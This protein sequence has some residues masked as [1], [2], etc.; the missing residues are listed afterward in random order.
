M[1][2]YTHQEDR[3]SN[4]KESKMIAERL[5]FQTF[6]NNLL[7]AESALSAFQSRKAMPSSYL[8]STTIVTA[9]ET[10]CVSWQGLKSK[11]LT[12]SLPTKKSST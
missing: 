4:E 10:H 9:T 12:A 1:K 8:L 5:E 7:E 3:S 6:N 2:H 11:Q